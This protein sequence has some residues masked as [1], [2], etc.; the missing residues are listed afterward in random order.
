[1]AAVSRL[2]RAVVGAGA[3]LAVLA[4]AATGAASATSAQAA[5]CSPDVNHI[6]CKGTATVRVG[7][8]TTHYTSVV[9]YANSKTH[10]LGEV[11]KP[12][13]FVLTMTFTGKN[14]KS[15]LAEFVGTDPKGKPAIARTTLTVTL[16]ANRTSGRVKGRT[17]FGGYGIVGSFTCK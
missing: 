1:M 9:C 14:R 5:S 6:W 13:K 4:A 16:N 12:S 3:T 8:K 7:K 17:D 11:W 2:G 15:T 10:A